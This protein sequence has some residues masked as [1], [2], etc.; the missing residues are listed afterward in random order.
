[1]DSNRELSVGPWCSRVPRRG[2]PETVCSLARAALGVVGTRRRVV[3]ATAA[4]ALLLLLAL[5]SVPINAE[6]ALGCEPGKPPRFVFGFAE[7]RAQ[8]GD[9]MGEPLSCEF[10]DPSGTGDIQ[11]RTTTGLAFWRKSTNHRRSRTV[12]ATGRTH[13]P[14]G[15]SGQGASLILLEQSSGRHP[16]P[17]RPQRRS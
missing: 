8:I 3:S 6:P 2:S 10:P 9:G 11:Q 14:A 4:A 12:T 16:R 5:P 7:L 1:M 13:L 15:W 17:P